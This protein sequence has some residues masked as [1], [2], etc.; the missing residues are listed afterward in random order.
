MP[1]LCVQ[2][3]RSVRT[4]G[5]HLCVA[6]LMAGQGMNARTAQMTAPLTPA[7]T[8]H[9]ALTDIRTIHADVSKALRGQAANPS[10]RPVSRIHVSRDI[11]RSVHLCFPITMC[12]YVLRAMRGK[13]VKLISKNVRQTR[14]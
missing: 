11:L 4:S 8:A 3:T 9:S 13:T 7:P 2:A 12:V 1:V 10:S 6:V 5:T 14:A